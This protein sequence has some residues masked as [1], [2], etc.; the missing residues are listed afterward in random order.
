MVALATIGGPDQHVDKNECSVVH[1]LSEAVK[2]LCE[3][4]ALQQSLDPA[5]VETEAVN[6]GR[7][8]CLSTV[9]R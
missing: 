2:V 7:I 1:G 4:T 3:P 5:L 8:V 6:K 9:T